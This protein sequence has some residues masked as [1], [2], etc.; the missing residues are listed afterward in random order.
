M[1]SLPILLRRSTV[2]LGVNGSSIGKSCPNASNC[3]A[4]AV[5]A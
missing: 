1:G 4:K 5:E 2:N 3:E